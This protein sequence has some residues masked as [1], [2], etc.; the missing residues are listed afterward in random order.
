MSLHYRINRVWNYEGNYLWLTSKG[1]RPGRRP[2]KGKRPGRRPRKGPTNFSIRVFRADFLIEVRQTI[3][4]R[5]ILQM[6]T[7]CTG[8]LGASLVEIMSFILAR[9]TPNVRRSCS[10]S[11][12]IKIY[13]RG[14]Q[15]KQ[16]V[17]VYIML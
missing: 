11:G 16:G 3:L 9:M 15:W 8:M 5:A 13:H 6:H 14:V 1:K 7:M 12:F 4:Y 10:R 17:V 2:R